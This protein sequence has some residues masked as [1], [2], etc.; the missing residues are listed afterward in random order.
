MHLYI[1][2]VLHSTNLLRLSPF[3]LE[4]EFLY[5]ARHSDLKLL[6]QSAICSETVPCLFGLVPTYSQ[7]EAFLSGTSSRNSGSLSLKGSPEPAV[8]TSKAL[9]SVQFYKNRVAYGSDESGSVI[10]SRILHNLT[11]KIHLFSSVPLT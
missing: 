9:I 3:V 2:F 7:Y 8:A 5:N 1:Q 6:I 11:V 10:I 4:T